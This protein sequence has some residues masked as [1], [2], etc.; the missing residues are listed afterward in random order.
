LRAAARL[1]ADRRRHE[2]RDGGD[3]RPR[4]PH[5]HTS[6]LLTD[7]P[8]QLSHHSSSVSLKLHSFKNAIEQAC[9]VAVQR[10]F[11]VAIAIPGGCAGPEHIL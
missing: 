7:T 3:R 6:P 8:R 1:R 5:R 9:H 10:G 11:T 2:K 4:W